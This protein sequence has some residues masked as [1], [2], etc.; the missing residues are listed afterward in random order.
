M[1]VVKREL[2]IEFAEL[3]RVEVRCKCGTVVLV[4][5]KGDHIRTPLKC[6]GCGEG[7][8]DTFSE[9]LTLFRKVYALFAVVEAD[10]AMPSVSVRIPFSESQ[11]Q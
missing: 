1:C 3:G 6:P 2:I 9:A 11:S 5:A 7:Y 10:G 4:S 8:G